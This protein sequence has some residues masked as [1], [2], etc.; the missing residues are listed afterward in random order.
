MTTLT[1]LTSPRSWAALAGGVLLAALAAPAF[2][3]DN[4]PVGD[5]P[6]QDAGANQGQEAGSGSQP[7]VTDGS[8]PGMG[9]GVLGLGEGRSAT[10]VVDCEAGAKAATAIA[11]TTFTAD[12]HADLDATL[13]P[14]SDAVLIDA[15]LAVDHQTQADLGQILAGEAGIAALV[16]TGV[17]QAFD[18]DRFARLAGQHLPEGWRATWIMVSVDSQGVVH[19]AAARVGGPDLPIEV[20]ID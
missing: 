18:L 20:C 15:F 10:L 16:R 11:G 8:T 14:P 2:A 17:P 6:K 7:S 3:G 12:L 19:V 9:T 1:S 13:M 5:L 4:D